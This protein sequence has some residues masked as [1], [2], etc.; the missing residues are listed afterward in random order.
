M[1]ESDCLFTCVRSFRCPEGL[2]QGD[3]NSRMREAP[4]CV[5]GASPSQQFSS[6]VK[7]HLFIPAKKITEAA[8]FLQSGTM[9]LYIIRLLVSYHLN[10]MCASFG[11]FEPF[12]N[13]V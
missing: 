1:S 3:S 4:S 12:S 7:G 8:L 5:S 10:L 11:I 9:V 2:Q 6:V 13:A